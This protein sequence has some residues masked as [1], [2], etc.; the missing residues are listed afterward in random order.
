MSNVAQLIFRFTL[1]SV[2]MWI[3]FLLPFVF[4]PQGIRAPGLYYF[5]YGTGGL[6]ILGFSI[7]CLEDYRAG[8]KFSSGMLIYVCMMLFVFAVISPIIAAAAP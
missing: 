3:S 1:G 6:L 7:Y 4:I 5:F 2:I 8:R